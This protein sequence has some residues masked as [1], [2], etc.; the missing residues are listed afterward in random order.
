MI[1]LKHLRIY[2]FILT[3]F[4]TH[5][6]LVAQ[7]ETK[8]SPLSF[9]S[10]DAKTSILKTEFPIIPEKSTLRLEDSISAISELP[11]RSGICLPVDFNLTNSGTITTLNDGSLCW[12]IRIECDGAEGI[13]LGFSKLKLP[14]GARLFLYSPDLE[15][16]IGSF[17]ITEDESNGFAIRPIAGNACIFELNL[18]SCSIK[19]VEVTISEIYFMYRN[20]REAEKQ[21]FKS[22]KSGSCEVNIS[23]QEGADWQRQKS[24]VVKLLSK[25]GSNLYYCTGSIVNNTSQDFAPLLLSAAHCAEGFGGNIA[26]PS[27]LAKWV[28]YFNY[29]TVSCKSSATSGIEQTMVGAEKLAMADNPSDMG[30]DFLLLKLKNSIPPSYLPYYCGWDASNSISPAGV[31]IH[32]PDGDFKKISTYT[33]PL[34]SDT[35]ESTPNTHWI[36]KWSSTLNGYGV[37]EGGSSGSP[38]FNNEGLIVGT[39][40][41]GYSDCNNVTEP[42]Y[43]GKVS[44]SWAS[45]GV[46][47]NQQL[48]PWLDPAN[49]GVL[50]I[51]GSF[52]EKFTTAEFVANTMVAPVDGYVLFTDLSS[53]N[54]KSWHW[55]F[56]N[57]SPSESFEKNPPFIYYNSFGSFDVKL[58]VSNDFNTD[59]IVKK[60]FVSIKAVVSPNPTLDGIVNILTNTGDTQPIV[61]DVFNYLGQMCA[62]FLVENPISNTYPIQLPEKAN[63]YY[64]RV[65]QGNS[66][67]T[68]KVIR[69]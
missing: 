40:T 14:D 58:V 17:S 43:F 65:S 27:D 50:K 2:I 63:L 9:N 64:L 41:G 22:E 11:Y 25:I 69:L 37:T 62:S 35:W 13:G 3:I 53:S 52:N 47:A 46:I 61:I 59:S 49:L 1:Q 34:V 7:I 39:L 24:S 48:K 57:G 45:N 10:S 30:S 60:D 18:P 51:P 31:C 4:S 44:Y 42:D 33:Q 36:A 28:F 67:Q 20:F 15:N 68:H 55:T 66:I 38:L 16:V 21:N 8:A 5:G 26:T 54:P 29:E 32:H 56:E 12:R 6:F 23:C 19:D